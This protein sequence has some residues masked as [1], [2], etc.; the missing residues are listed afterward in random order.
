QTDHFFKSMMMPVLTPA[1]VQEYIDFGVHGYALSR[2]SGCWVAFKA[3]AD[4]VET[5]AS[6]D[7]DPRRVQ[8]RLPTDFAL[9]ADGLNI[10]WPDPPLVQEKRLLHYKLYAALAYC[11]SNGLNRTVIDSPAPRLGIITSGKSYLDV[12]Q[13]FDDLGIDE[14]LAAE[15]GIR[16][17]KVGM[18]WPLEADGVR[19][20]AEGL[21][22][23]LVVEE[24]RQLL[25]YQ[26]KE[27]LYNWREDVRPRVIGKFD[28]KGEWAHVVRPDGTIDHG[29]WLLPAAGE[30]TP[31]MIA[32]VIASRIER[33]FTSER[34]R[35]RLAF[36]EAKE[37]TL[38][39]RNFA[40]DRV[41][42]F[43]SGCP[44]NTSTH[45]PEGSRALAGIGCHYMA[46]W[47]DR[48]T[49]SFTQMGGEGATWLGQAPFS[50]TPH[51]FQN[52]GD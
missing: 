12:R 28:E 9:P 15:I 46:Q 16:L 23:I 14:A 31:A 1:G 34:I 18:V 27:E 25:E 11:R 45:V 44:H 10:R 17:Y 22:E 5:S 36:L 6:V 35:S 7:V 13:A 49:Q 21:D 41:P 3:L 42:T 20:F 33:F 52:I 4:T 50:K 24:K 8:V 26:L 37:R 30:L 2:Y 19:A 29:D 39:A 43:C 40:I 51:V 38:A 48:N 47:M 32:R